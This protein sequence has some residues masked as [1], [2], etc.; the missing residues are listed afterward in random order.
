MYGADF[1]R[2]LDELQSGI[3]STGGLEQ[4][5]LSTGRFMNKTLEL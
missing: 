2:K 1:E 5:F 3:W 4:T